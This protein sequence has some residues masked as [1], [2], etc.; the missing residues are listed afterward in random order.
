MTGAALVVAG[1]SAIEVEADESA[2]V[3]EEEGTVVFVASGDGL[4]GG[5][6]GFG[7]AEGFA[8][9]ATPA[10]S[11]RK[12][13]RSPALFVLLRLFDDDGGGIELRDGRA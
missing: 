12:E 8:A 7:E 13:L 9:F 4:V 10:I 6:A 3:F 1:P 5:A 2:T 11:V